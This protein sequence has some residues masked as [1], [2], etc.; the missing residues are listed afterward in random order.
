MTDKPNDI[1]V[2]AETNFRSQRRK[3]GLRRDDRLRHMYV[4]GKTGMGK[5]TMLENMIIDDIQR[6]YGVGVVDPH[7]DL[8][9][10]VL[11]FIPP[12]RVNDVVYINPADLEYPVAFNI[13][14]TPGERY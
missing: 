8:A 7:G 14:E 13:L 6:G 9:E 10:K 12:S 2:F 3:F 11:D 5:S 1:T 4:I